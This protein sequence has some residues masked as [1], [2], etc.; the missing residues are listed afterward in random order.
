MDFRSA[1][2]AGLNQKDDTCVLC[3]AP[4][5]KDEKILY[6]EHKIGIGILSKRATFKAH[7]ACGV[8]A[9]DVLS[10]KIDEAFCL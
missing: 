10:M 7:V 1:L 3:E 4:I 8:V 5:K 2:R 6:A 9:R